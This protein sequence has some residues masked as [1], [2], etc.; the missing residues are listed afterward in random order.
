MQEYFLSKIREKIPLFSLFL[1]K[2]IPFRKK[3]ETGR[4]LGRGDR[5][6]ADYQIPVVQ[7]YSL[8]RGDC[9][10]GILEFYPETA[11]L[12]RVDSSRLGIMTGSGFCGNAYGGIQGVKGD[13][14]TAICPQGFGKQQVF[15]A[16]CNGIIGHI[17]AADID[18]T[19]H[20]QSQTLTLT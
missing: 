11:T 2:C 17:L 4:L 15:R 14:V 16:Y 18:R 5:T 20:S 12:L 10:L 13:K 7:N 6:G 9:T 19:S 8:S 3:T 1:L